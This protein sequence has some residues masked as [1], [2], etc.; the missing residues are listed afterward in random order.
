MQQLVQPL[1]L[2]QPLEAVLAEV[3]HGEL[4][5]LVE[6]RVRRVRKEDLPAVT[7]VADT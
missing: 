7:G 4:R 2:R 6:Q 1:L 5:T 3:A